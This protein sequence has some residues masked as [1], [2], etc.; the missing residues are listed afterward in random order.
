L[1]DLVT[2]AVSGMF[3]ERMRVKVSRITLISVVLEVWSAHIDGS[4]QVN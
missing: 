1:E 2:S 4:L 3:G